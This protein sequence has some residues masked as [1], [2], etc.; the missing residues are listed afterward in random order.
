MYDPR[1]GLSNGDD[2]F[3]RAIQ[4]M[5][6]NQIQQE[7]QQ[8]RAD[9]KS[10]GDL[11]KQNTS[12]SGY[13]HNGNPIT[14]QADGSFVGKNAQGQPYLVPKGEE[15]A[16]YKVDHQ[17]ALMQALQQGNPLA[18]Q[19]LQDQMKPKS[20]M[21][22][23]DKLAVVA[24]QNANKSEKDKHLKQRDITQTMLG[25]DANNF[26]NKDKGDIFTALNDASDDPDK[27]NATIAAINAN[28]DQSIFRHL[29]PGLPLKNLDTSG[30]TQT[31]QN[32]KP[33]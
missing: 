13:T 22:L 23:A 26:Y 21:D 17:Q 25:L 15:K 18:L 8:G 3:T 4:L 1:Q 32:Y 30:F 29:V 7:N 27:F 19:L 5:G 31:M 12:V 9:A 10:L 28:T 2:S 11:L 33:K 6:M 24:A 20:G 16:N 14:P